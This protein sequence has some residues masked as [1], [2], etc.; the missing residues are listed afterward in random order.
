MPIEGGKF[1]PACQ[2]LNDAAATECVYCGVP[3]ESGVSSTASTTSQVA[4]YTTLLSP[5][6]LNNVERTV[7]ENGIAFYLSDH[8]RPF[9][10]R[11]E[12][13]I[14]LGRKTDETLGKIVD[15]TPFNAFSMGISRR[16]VRIQ[17]MEENG[18]L[19]TDLNSTNGTWLNEVRL[20][21]D[22]PTPLPNAVQIRLG[23]M[24][25]YV[26]YRLKK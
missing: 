25:L 6:D 17:R 1:C 23:K 19:I 5:E 20:P 21:P 14:I 16:H 13:D 9:D 24:R 15:L 11:T 2:L 8:E 4:G 3:F 10:V 26:I 18:Y 7:P 22:Q 12:D